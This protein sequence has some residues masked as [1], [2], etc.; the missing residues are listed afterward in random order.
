MVF[1]FVDLVGVVQPHGSAEDIFDESANELFV[2]DQDPEIEGGLVVGGVG[3]SLLWIG[4]VSEDNVQVS[5]EFVGIIFQT[6]DHLDVLELGFVEAGLDFFGIFDLLT[7]SRPVEVP[8][9]GGLLE[10]L[11]LPDVEVGPLLE[12]L[13]I[14][15]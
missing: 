5:P 10:V 13:D 1:K 4:Q 12:A 11:D 8:V 15:W 3:R 2:L 9:F 14:H 6:F 7:V